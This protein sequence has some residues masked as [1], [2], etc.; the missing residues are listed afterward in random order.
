MTDTTLV[1]IVGLVESL[2]PTQMAIGA[3]GVAGLWAGVIVSLIA[4][5]WLGKAVKAW[6]KEPS[7]VHQEEVCWYHKKYKADARGCGCPKDTEPKARE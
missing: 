7:R 3:E 6:K 1:Q 4:I 5:T 2:S